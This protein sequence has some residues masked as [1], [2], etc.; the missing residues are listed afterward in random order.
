MR[1]VP[2]AL[3][4]IA[5]AGA[6][7][8]SNSL[9]GVFVLDDRPSIE[10]NPNIES[11]WPLSRSLDAPPGTCA[12]GRPL[13]ALSL[14]VNYALGEREVLGYHLFNIV[15]HVLA[16][17]ALFGVV[18]RAMLAAGREA[19]SLPIALSVALL[20]VV[21]PLHTDAL[22]HVVYRNGTMMAGCYLA[23]LYCA[24]RAFSSPAPRRWSA[25]AVLAAILAMTA[26]EVAVSLPLCVLAFDRFFGAGTFRGALRA[27]PGMYAGLAASWVVLALCVVIGDRGESVGLEHSEIIDSFDYLRTQ[28][29]AILIYQRLAFWP[30]PL[31]F[32]YDGYDLVREW[33][34]VLLPGAAL[35]VLFALSLVAFARRQIAGLLGL[36]FFAILAPT[37]SFIPL[38]GELVAEHR[39]VLPL[40]PLIVLVV[41]LALKLLLGMG[42][43]RKVIGAALLLTVCAA[44]GATTF[45]RNRLYRSHLALWTDTVQKRP[46][47]PRAW[48]HFGIALKNEGRDDEAAEA[49]RRAIQF[50]REHGMAH[51]NYA[52][53]LFRQGDEARA[54]EHYAL[55]TRYEGDNAYVRFNFGSL[56]V[57]SGSVAQ[58]LHQFAE[59][60]RLDPT[61]TLPTT[62]TAWILATHVDP[63]VRDG[64]RALVLAQSYNRASGFKDPRGLDI[65]AAALAETGDF[66]EAVRIAQQARTAAVSSGQR[67][68]ARQI[69]LRLQGYSSGRPFRSEG[70][71]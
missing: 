44:L 42:K 20:W 55:A 54:L 6:L 8:Y 26:K 37:S 65:L 15:V 61:F 29:Q 70:P 48:N 24:L 19:V 32:D 51:F 57:K 17:F 23:T 45:A 5:A 35:V 60:S 30:A 38:S 33:G 66:S 46:D 27:R 22:N 7:C 14:A 39:M 16:A 71:R 36:V 63:S 3:L 62:R 12:S 49:F 59:A 25:L 52:N 10:D 9:D 69:E 18:R 2:L 56:L 50:N 31:V 11:L 68:L 41:L 34:P 67:D 53:L 64:Q 28:A 4:A 47:N 40:A 21:H 58:G 43:Q 13:A 1:I